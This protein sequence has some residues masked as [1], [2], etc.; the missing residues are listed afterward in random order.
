MAKKTYNQKMNAAGDLPKIQDLSGKPEFVTRYGGSKMLIAAPVQY[1][2][3]MAKVPEG[4]I[5]TSDK[6]RDYLAGKHGADVTCPLTAGIFMNICA[7]ASEERDA[8]RIPYWRTV[9]TKGELNEKYPGGTA[10]QQALLESEGHTVIQKGKKYYVKD[11]EQKLWEI[12][13]RD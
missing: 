12:E 10:E 5:I 1:N 6:V 11:Y 3:I 7:Q 4:K 2:E 8:D 13:D 9:K